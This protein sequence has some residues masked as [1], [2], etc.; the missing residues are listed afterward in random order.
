MRVVSHCPAAGICLFVFNLPPGCDDATMVQVFARFGS[1]LKSTVVRQA[2]PATKVR[3]WGGRAA[4]IE[5]LVLATLTAWLKG[6]L[7]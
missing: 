4:E 7:T 6:S 3:C 5:P 1:V 2:S